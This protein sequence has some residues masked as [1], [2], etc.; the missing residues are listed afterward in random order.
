MAT[1][2]ELRT[3]LQDK[4]RELFQLN[5]PDLDFGVYRVMH[6]K[7]KEVDHFLNVR[8]PKTIAA[9]F[10]DSSASAVAEKEAAYAK[11]LEQAKAFGAPRPEAT[12]PVQEARAALD[13]ARASAG[14]ESEVYDHLYHFFER[15][16]D[17]GD[18]VSLRRLSR[19]TDRKAQPYAIPYAGEEVKL[20]WANADQYYVKTGENFSHFAFDA[21]KHPSVARLSSFE[22]VTRGIPESCPVRFEVVDADE[23]EHGNVKDD[24]DRFFI[25]HAASPCEMKDGTL[26][27]RFE[28]RADS[29]KSGT[30]A[31]WQEKRRLDALATLKD[32]VVAAGLAPTVREFLYTDLDRDVKGKDPRI[33]LDVYLKRYFARNTADYFIHKDL[34]GFLRRELDFYVKNELIEL[35]DFASARP[36]A[37]AKWLGKVQ[38]FRAIAEQIVTFLAQLED[39]QKRLWLKKKFVVQCDYCLTLDRVPAEML[40]E[41]FANAAQKAEWT[42][43]GLPT[44]RHERGGAGRPA[45]SNGETDSPLVGRDVPVAP[46]TDARM[47]DTRFFDESFKQRLLASIDDFDSQCDGVLIHGEN[48]QALNLL[49]ERYRSQVKC[50]YIDPP[51]NTGS[52]GFPYKDG[53]KDSSWASFMFDR[54]A[55]CKHMLIGDGLFLSSIGEDEVGNFKKIT[56]GHFVD[57]VNSIVVRRQ[58]KNLSLQFLDKGLTSLSVGFEYVLSWRKNS[59]ATINPVYAKKAED[60]H[61]AGY[62]KGFWNNADRETMRYGLLGYMPSE[63]QWKWCQ[64]RA[65][66]AVANYN[67]YLERYSVDETLEA[68]WKRTGEC[69]EFIRRNPDGKGKNQGVEHWIPPSDEKLRTSNWTD[70]LASKAIATSFG[71]DFPN[72]KNDELI[73]QLLLMVGRENS[74][75]LDYF[76]GSGTTGHAVIDLNRQDGGKRKY[77]LVEIGEHFDTVLKPRIE[78]VVYSPD[79]KDGRPVTAEKGVSHCFKY[80]RLESYEDVLNNL[81]VD[82]E[83]GAAFAGVKDYFLRYMLDVETRES[84]SLLNAAEFANPFAM[85]LSVKKAAGEERE[86]RVVDL[87][88]TFNFLIG[89]RVERTDE[90]RSFDAAFERPSDPELPE[91]GRTK[92]VVKD[93]IH[94]AADGAWKFRTVEGWL[95]RNRFAPDDGARDR[96]L[97]VWRTLTDD[98]EKDNAVL[99][100]FLRRSGFNALDGEFDVIYVNGSDN[101]PNLR[102]EGDTWKV[103][104][105]E[106]DFAA[107]MWEE[108]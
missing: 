89:L 42:R 28:Y 36:E 6:A 58:D 26:V 32:A 86:E 63:G 65:L 34:G 45:L 9:A 81:V 3:R 60:G 101:V 95:P 48:F 12:K 54:I 69:L 74:L 24:K 68:Y 49:Q 21:A 37:V 88:E 16:Y 57:F 103:R 43:L 108:A 4:L 56:E 91:D 5:E 59:T 10:A 67:E 77:I 83:K 105:I 94:A 55:A 62:W 8:L 29:E 96:V 85:R 46:N 70:V 13:A 40:D 61:K 19:E 11:A 51:Y 23:G 35:D 66:K 22:K 80:L 76:A 93:K 98:R 107:R 25:L 64:E 71:L 106:E 27:V 72:P 17:K 18:F 90:V 52:D 78:K 73:A 44:E 82:N 20:H 1:I 47:V 41:V 53:Y 87:V 38:V 33:L 15:Y 14:A 30:A 2:D 31:K 102:R 50:I 99:D 75:V 92:L 104:S 84:P 7:A 79:W 97:V 39:F 100:A